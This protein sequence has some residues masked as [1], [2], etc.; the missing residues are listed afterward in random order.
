MVYT[1][2][3]V[4][5]IVRRAVEEYEKSTVLFT[6]EAG[7]IRRHVVLSR[8]DR[9]R[10]FGEGQ[11]LSFGKPLRQPRA[12]LYKETLT[13]VG[14]ETMISQTGI[15]GGD[16]DRTRVVLSRS[17][18]INLGLDL[19]EYDKT[20]RLPDAA[21]TLAGPAGMIPAGS[22]IKCTERNITL[23]EY[24]AGKLGLADGDILSVRVQG[25]RSLTFHKVRVKTGYYSTEFHLDADEANAAGIQDGDPVEIGFF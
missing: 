17:D 5:D 18:M 9:E 13:L 1:K 10:L 6:A 23:S 24:S 19:N 12:Y 8:K 25:R 7:I 21:L 16:S 22:C 14:K 2:E 15:L 3:Q 11:A 4:C 20:G